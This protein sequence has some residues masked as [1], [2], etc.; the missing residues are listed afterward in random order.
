MN[1]T[2]K[3]PGK[4]I[5]K[6]C[7]RFQINILAMQNKFSNQKLKNEHPNKKITHGLAY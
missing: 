6:I 7:G 1:E 5:N 2:F 3:K 4:N